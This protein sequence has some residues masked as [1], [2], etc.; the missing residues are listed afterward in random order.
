VDEVPSD[1]VAK[2]LKAMSDKYLQRIPGLVNPILA[3]SCATGTFGQLFEVLL[4][5]SLSLCIFSSITWVSPFLSSS[6]LQSN[7]GEGIEK[8]TYLLQNVC[9]N[10]RTMGEL[11]PHCY[12]RLENEIKAEAVAKE[13]D[14]LVPVMDWQDF[15]ILAQVRSFQ[16]KQRLFLFYSRIFFLFLFELC[17]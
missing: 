4:L 2:V 10:E 15:K 5:F 6:L 9:L 11:L 16:S 13:K 3:V 8:F 1:H 14:G 12:L 7:L 17:F